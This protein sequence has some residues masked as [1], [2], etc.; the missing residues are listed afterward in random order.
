MSKWIEN[1]ETNKFHTKCDDFKNFDK[2]FEIIESFWKC[3]IIYLVLW[4]QY[5][6]TN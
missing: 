3:I 6:T 1:Y 5:E 2:V 4:K